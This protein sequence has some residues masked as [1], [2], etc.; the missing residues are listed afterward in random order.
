MTGLYFGPLG[1]TVTFSTIA[2]LR[3][4][5]LILQFLSF[6]ASD[7]STAVLS[8]TRRRSRGADFGSLS[9]SFPGT[10]FAMLADLGLAPDLAEA[11][12]QDRGA[13]R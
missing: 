12:A 7:G 1:T 10:D 3:L 11:V 9:Q 2:F 6:A 4:I 13:T 5:S 8:P